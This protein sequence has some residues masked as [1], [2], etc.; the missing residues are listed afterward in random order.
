M[1]QISTLGDGSTFH[2]STVT[3]EDLD[4]AFLYLRGGDKL[5]STDNTSKMNLQVRIYFP[6]GSNGKGGKLIISHKF[7]DAK[8]GY[9]AWPVTKDGSIHIM[10]HGV[11]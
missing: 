11:P 4:Q 8:L 9:L 6:S 1:V 3:V 10:M 5:I 2:F 7:T